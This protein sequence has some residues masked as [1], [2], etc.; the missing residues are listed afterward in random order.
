[1]VWARQLGGAGTDQG[2]G[3]AV[4]SSGQCYVTGFF[5]GAASFGDQ[6]L[7]S[8]GD[9]DTFICQFDSAG[10]VQWIQQAGAVGKSQGSAIAV[11]RH[12]NCLVTGYY[13]SLALFGTNIVSTVG[14]YDLFLAKYDPRGNLVWVHNTTSSAINGA[15]VATDADGN[16]YVTGS[17]IGPA[18]FG[19]MALTNNSVSELFLVKY[20]ADG[21]FIWAKQSGGQAACSGFGV[22]VDSAGTCYLTGSING[23]ASFG[24]KLLTS[25]Q[26]SDIVV[27]KLLSS[28]AASPASLTIQRLTDSQ[29]QIQFTGDSCASYRLQ[30]S[31]DLNQWTTLTTAN[32]LTAPV[33]FIEDSTPAR[34][35]RF[36]RVVSP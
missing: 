22:A 30:G 1:M 17:F 6:D 14:F 15:S 7:T 33:V 27:A 20:D 36:F 9:Q 13:D 3:I 24:S 23:I 11:D 5:E 32:A 34:N 28:T 16:G 21:N 8:V 12:G 4:D 19:D 25:S 10:K 29:L 35:Y 18:S 2:T 31:V 26:K